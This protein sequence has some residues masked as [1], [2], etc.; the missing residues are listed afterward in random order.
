LR[1][2]FVRNKR[3]TH[4][5]FVCYPLMPVDTSGVFFPFVPAESISLSG[6]LSLVHCGRPAHP[7]PLTRTFWDVN[8][9]IAN[10]ALWHFSDLHL[11]TDGGGEALTRPRCRGAGIQLGTE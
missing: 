10:D 3:L 9:G 6:C 11:L 5:F 4:E 2:D 8:I 1:A 7:P